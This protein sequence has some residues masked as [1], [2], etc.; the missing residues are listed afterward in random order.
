MT[1]TTTRDPTHT[2]HL[3]EGSLEE[4]IA[5]MLRVLKHKHPIGYN[6]HVEYLGLEPSGKVWR[7]RL[8]RENS[9]D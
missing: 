4:V 8:R 3:I 2:T 6:T 9:C 5:G 7:C 1:E